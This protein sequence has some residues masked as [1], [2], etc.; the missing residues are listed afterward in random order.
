MALSINFNLMKTCPNCSIEH[1]KKGTYCSDSCKQEAYRNRKS[2]N[3]SDSNSVGAINLAAIPTQVT[4]AALAP[5]KALG[6]NVA[7]SVNSSLSGYNL[8]FSGFALA[9]FGGYGGFKFIQNFVKNPSATDYV[10]GIAGG[11]VAGILADVGIKKLCGWIADDTESAKQMVDSISNQVSQMQIITGAQMQGMTFAGVSLLQ[12]FSDAIAP[13][14]PV[15]SV[16]QITGSSNGGKIYFLTR[17]AASLSRS[18]KVLFISTEQGQD[19]NVKL[20]FSRMDALNVAYATAFTK[21]EIESAVKQYAPTVLI[22]DS[23]SNLGLSPVDERNFIRDLSR[24]VNLL[25]YS[26]HATK[27]GG[28]AGSNTLLHDATVMIECSQP[29]PNKFSAVVK[30]NRCGEI[31][32]DI[33]SLVNA[34][35]GV[36][37]FPIATNFTGK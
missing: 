30:K 32:K 1:S 37:V 28:F 11:S 36:K 13:A 15:H 10:I 24:S 19:E 12:P 5:V 34:S 26:L 25:L 35:S 18:H 4:N 3:L 33:L 17:C 22:V 16:V 14:V 7:K 23:A 20:R 21:S 27:E 29:E 8:G 9:G 6:D 2:K 31:G